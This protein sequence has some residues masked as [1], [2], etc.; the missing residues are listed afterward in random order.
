MPLSIIPSSSIHV[1]ANLQ[2][3]VN[4]Q[5][6]FVLPEDLEIFC[7]MVFTLVG[8]PAWVES[9]NI[10][11]PLKRLYYKFLKLHIFLLPQ[12]IHKQTVNILPMRPDE[13]CDLAGPC[14]EFLFLSSSNCELPTSEHTN[15]IPQAF[16]LCTPL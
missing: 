4:P 6:I 5:R 14:H 12:Q 3:H 9:N 16:G 7:M 1:A 10:F 13:L 11:S 8:C 15:E 2:I